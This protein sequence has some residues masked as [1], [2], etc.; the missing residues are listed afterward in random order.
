MYFKYVF[1]MFKAFLRFHITE[2]FRSL[3]NELIILCLLNIL[4]SLILCFSINNGIVGSFQRK[5][6]L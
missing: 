4:S 1:Q 3:V 2:Y 5:V 6:S